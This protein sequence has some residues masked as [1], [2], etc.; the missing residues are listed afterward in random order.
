MPKFLVDYTFDTLELLL[1][2][3]SHQQ[4]S[5]RR[6]PLFDESGIWRLHEYKQ[7]VCLLPLKG[8]CSD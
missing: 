4:P 5:Q 6:Y 3:Y 2:L 7:V 1:S 8:F